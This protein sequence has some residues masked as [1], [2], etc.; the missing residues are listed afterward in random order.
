[1][2]VAAT[3]RCALGE[4]LPTILRRD[5]LTSIWCRCTHE[6]VL[7]D[8]LEWWA[9]SQIDNKQNRL[10]LSSLGFKGSR[11]ARARQ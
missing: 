9:D 1:M 3:I 8:A 7:E 2:E 10:L 11:S 5:R 6:R 4:T